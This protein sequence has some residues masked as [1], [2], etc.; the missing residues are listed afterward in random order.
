MTARLPD[1]A[2][3]ILFAETEDLDAARAATAKLTDATRRLLYVEIEG[4]LAHAASSKLVE[5]QPGVVE[6]PLV[7]GRD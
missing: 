7:D 6:L 1:E 5:A 3:R 4:Q 2:R